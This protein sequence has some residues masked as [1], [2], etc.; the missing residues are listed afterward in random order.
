MGYPNNI[1]TILRESEFILKEKGSQFIA[2]SRP[3]EALKEI[4]EYLF[5]IKKNYYDASHHCFSYKLSSGFQKYSDAGEPNGTAGIRIFN[6]QNHFGVT[7]VLTVVVRYFGGVKLG[8]GPLGNAYY[9]AAFQSLSSAPKEEKI[10]FQRAEIKYP[11]D[12][13]QQI[14]HFISKFGLI[15]ESNSYEDQP[16]LFC[17]VRSNLIAAFNS[18]ISNHQHKQIVFKLFNEFTYISK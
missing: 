12:Q 16:T 17:Y 3:F 14:H 8:V 5:A 18:E 13:V 1:T 10:L 9:E 7:N 2:I 11:Y 4:E 15:I 6:A